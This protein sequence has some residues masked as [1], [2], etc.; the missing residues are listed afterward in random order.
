MDALWYRRARRS[1]STQRPMEW[2]FSAGTTSW[3]D[4]SAPGKIGRLALEKLTGSDPPDRWARSAQN[5]VHWAT[6]IGWGVQFGMALV[7]V[8]R[9]RWWWGLGL[10]AAAWAASY[11]VLPQLDIYKPIGEYDAATLTQDLS[12]HLL[13]GAAAGVTYTAARRAARGAS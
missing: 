10:G 8:G 12:A 3:D 1:G 7:R 9:P 13:Y 11:A 4:V 5:V 2:E 6:G